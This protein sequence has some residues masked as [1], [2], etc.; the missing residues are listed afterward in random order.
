MSNL[1]IVHD[2]CVTVL[3]NFKTQDIKFNLIYVDIPFNTGKTQSIHG[4]SY[5]DDFGDDF[6]D[7][8]LVPKLELAHHVLKDD[9]SFFIH[10][11][12]REI[13]YVKVAL[14]KIFGR[15]NFMNEIIWSYDYGGR[16]KKKW[17]A[18]HDTILW[19]AKNHKKYTF[20]YDAIDRI[21]YMAPK[22]VGPVKEA[23]GKTPT[24]VWWSTIVPTMG[25]ERVNYPTQKPMKIIERIVKVHSNKDDSLLD[26]FAGSGTFGEAALKNGR[27]V[28]LVDNN[29]EAIEVMTKRLKKYIAPE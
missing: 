4:K 3:E 18:K 21:P 26:F 28:T 8:W 7:V 29:L 27:N 20:N 6:V 15:S 22:F 13:H 24:T 9:G 2:D 14:D 25:K 1:S 10:A 12:S 17:S 23:I 5:S 19:Y 16:S 11:D